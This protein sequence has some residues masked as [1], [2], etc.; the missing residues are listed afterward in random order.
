MSL[1]TTRKSS[2]N[3]GDEDDGEYGNEGEGV[4]RTPVKSKATPINPTEVC[5]IC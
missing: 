4:S 1:P 5:T 2:H 3:H